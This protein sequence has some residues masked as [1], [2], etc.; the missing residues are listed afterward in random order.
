M[1]SILNCFLT[2]SKNRKYF[3][4]RKKSKIAIKS[5][6][7]PM[8]QNIDLKPN[9]WGGHLFWGNNRTNWRV[10]R[11][12]HVGLVDRGRTG[13]MCRPFKL[14]GQCPLKSPEIADII[15]L[16][17]GEVDATLHQCIEKITPKKRHRKIELTV[18]DPIGLQ[19]IVME[20]RTK[21]AREFKE[22]VALVIYAI[23]NGKLYQLPPEQILA[24][25]ILVLQSKTPIGGK[26]KVLELYEEKTGVSRA[27]AYRHLRKV[28][29]GESPADKKYRNA[30][31]PVISGDLELKIRQMWYEDKTIGYRKMYKLLGSPKRPSFDAVKEFMRKLK[32][33][34][35]MSRLA[36]KEE[37]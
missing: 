26:K 32:K 12:G 31:K 3:L 18:F 25:N 29:R 35:K 27:T 34:D 33:E 9:Q 19:L 6:A 28:K 16:M 20:S 10:A 30:M 36:S 11:V 13:K 37:K 7:P 1:I 23:L 4:I 14:K 8:K 5:G 21:K 15:K 17:G 24:E 2:Y 22:A